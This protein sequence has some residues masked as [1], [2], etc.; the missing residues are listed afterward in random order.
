[1]ADADVS[2]TLE[3][4]T[5]RDA[6]RSGKRNRKCFASIVLYRRNGTTDPTGCERFTHPL[7][8]YNRKERQRS[9]SLSIRTRERESEAALPT[10]SSRY[11][12]PEVSDNE[13]NGAPE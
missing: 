2:F 13:R 12:G 10:I 6:D 1:M 4:A 11:G 7:Y 5:Y 9:S 8:L 3:I